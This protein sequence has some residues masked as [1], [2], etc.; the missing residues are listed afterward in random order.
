MFRRP[1]SI[2]DP[3]D[4][5][6]L[7]SLM[8]PGLPT[9]A[10]PPAERAAS[11]AIGHRVIG[12]L[13]EAEQL[14]QVRLPEEIEDE[15]RSRR[16]QDALLAANLRRELTIL[17]PVVRAAC[18]IEPIL[19]KGA[20][21]AERLYPDRTLRPFRDLDLV[22]PRHCLTDAAKALQAE[23]G[24]ETSDEPWSGYSERAGHHISL[25]RRLGPHR[26]VVDLHW[27]LSDDPA[28]R[29]LD[30]H[31]LLSRAGRLA[32]AGGGRVA[33]PSV[34]DQL[35][36]LSVHLLHEPVKRLLWIH[37]IALAAERATEQEWRGAFAA[38]RE[39]QLEWVLNRALDYAARH[40]GL[41]R[42]RPSGPGRPPPWGPLRAGERLDGWIGTQLGRLALGGWHEPDGYLRSAT[43]ARLAGLGRRIGAR[44]PSG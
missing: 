28:A 30:H 10:A 33:V 16:A 41:S 6:F 23:V 15:L 31:R 7:A 39:L 20:A 1:L 17:E 2:T 13:L 8:R 26:L 29:G 38:A 5:P 11:A 25:E 32:L 35:I 12:Y 21:V 9:R 43:R 18:G 24:Y 42:E 4:A 3:A 40:L 27:R 34:E 44:R 14:G 36:V 37:D 19:I 22:V